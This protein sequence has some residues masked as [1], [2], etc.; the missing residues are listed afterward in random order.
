MMRSI[1]RLQHELSV[2]CRHRILH[3]LLKL[4]FRNRNC[5]SY[6]ER[7]SIS[8]PEGI[9]MHFRM[10]SSW[11]RVLFPGK[12]GALSTNSANTQPTL[13][14]SI[15]SWQVVM[16][17][18]ASGGRYHLDATY[19]VSTPSFAQSVETLRR[20]IPKSQIL[21]YRLLQFSK[22]LE[23]LISRCTRPDRC[24]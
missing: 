20:A 10:S 5:A 19:S 7:R 22:M 17:R 9:P 11:S 6:E 14:K 4:K 16:P 8:L 23:G 13:H 18:R 24:R 21:T 1:S 15:E 2:Y 12:S 3:R